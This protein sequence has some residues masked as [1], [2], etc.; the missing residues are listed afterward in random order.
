[1]SGQ[2]QVQVC[3]ARPGLTLL[4]TL[5]VAAG[6]TLEQAI[7]QS[8]VLHD[9]PEID[10]S[11]MRVGIFNKLKTLDTVLQEHDRVEIYRPLVADPKQSR[12]ARAEKRAAGGV[13]N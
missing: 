2:L 10:L 5:A 1:M 12:R 3:Y 7:A 6:C 13:G 11:R 9:A 4:R 8:G